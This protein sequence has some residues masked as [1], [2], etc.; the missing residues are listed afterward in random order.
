MTI[1]SEFKKMLEDPEE[2]LRVDT[3]IKT[4]TER[5]V[6][7]K[8]IQIFNTITPFSIPQ[9]VSI[10]DSSY[11]M[12]KRDC[13]VLLAYIKFFEQRLGKM[14]EMN[15]SDDFKKMFETLTE[16]DGIEEENIYDGTMFG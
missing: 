8:W 6:Y 2:D 12:S 14:K 11:K 16:A 10:I 4:P 13:I 7:E 9:G 15:E 1:I 5:A 3:L